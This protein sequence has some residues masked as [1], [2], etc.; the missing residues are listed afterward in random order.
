G[1]TFSKPAAG[2]LVSPPPWS[3]RSSRATGPDV[4]QPVTS[5]SVAARSAARR[6]F[7]KPFI[8]WCSP[9]ARRLVGDVGQNLCRGADR[10][11]LVEI[12]DMLGKHAD[13]AR[14]DILADAPGLQRAVQ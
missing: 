14:R 6:A 5:A 10:A 3:S 9:V 1:W 4:M 7:E 13:A 8:A 2:S 12:H 11:P